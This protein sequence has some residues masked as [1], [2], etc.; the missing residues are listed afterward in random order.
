MAVHVLCDL[1]ALQRDKG[2]L[3]KAAATCRQALQLATDYSRFGGR[4]MPG[5]DYAH[6]RLS[7]VLCQWNDLDGGDRRGPAPGA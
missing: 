7:E 3:H 4:W 1:A 5:I 2:Q 6:A